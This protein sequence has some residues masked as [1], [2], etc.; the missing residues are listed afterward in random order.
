MEGSV[1]GFLKAES[2][3][4]DTGSAHWAN[5][6]NYTTKYTMNSLLHR[7]KVISPSILTVFHNGKQ[8]KIEANNTTLPII[9]ISWDLL[10]WTYVEALE[11]VHVEAFSQNFQSDVIELHIDCITRRLRNNVMHI[12]MYTLLGLN[13]CCMILNNENN[14]MFLVLMS[15]FYDDG[16]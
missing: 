9:M 16:I 11:L 5:N 4:S 15:F 2:K 10:S 1:L 8:E 6:W 12:Y 7:R 14:Q 3:V 13:Y